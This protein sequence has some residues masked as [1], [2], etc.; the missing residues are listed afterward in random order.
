MLLQGRRTNG[1]KVKV[2]GLEGA[3]AMITGRRF[4][5]NRAGK[6][7][8]KRALERVVGWEKERLASIPDVDVIEGKVP[9]L[10]SIG[11][12][13]QIPDIQI[14][15]IPEVHEILDPV[16]VRLLTSSCLWTGTM[17]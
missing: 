9:C 4:L 5:S 10:G 3:V 15:S 16:S 6:Q 17:L 7:P 12:K 2:K 1:V 13:Y 8:A 11:L 14:Q